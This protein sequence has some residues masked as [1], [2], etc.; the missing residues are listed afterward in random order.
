MKIISCIRHIFM[1]LLCLTTTYHILCMEAEEVKANPVTAL[2]TALSRLQLAEEQRS[3][4]EESQ[5]EMGPPAQEASE[6]LAAPSSETNTLHL[7]PDSP[8]NVRRRLRISPGVD[9]TKTFIIQDEDGYAYCWFVANDE[10][11]TPDMWGL[12]PESLSPFD[13]NRIDL[14]ASPHQERIRVLTDQV[15]TVPQEVS[16][17]EDLYEPE[18]LKTG[19]L[20]PA[21]QQQSQSSAS[22]TPNSLPSTSAA[23]DERIHMPELANKAAELKAL[24]A[25]LEEKKACEAYKQTLQSCCSDML[26]LVNNAKR[27]LEVKPK[28]ETAHERN[29]H[30]TE[31]F[32]KWYKEAKK[33]RASYQAKL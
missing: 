32:K 20:S 30:H 9:Q 8:M 12:V 28:E 25:Q 6:E 31:S 13:N 21:A 33:R 17:A 7:S 2:R 4:R 22:T 16:E 1:S 11:K 29:S 3:A 10:P 18:S 27:K 5:L 26:G 23:R 24:L 14:S 15:C 19:N